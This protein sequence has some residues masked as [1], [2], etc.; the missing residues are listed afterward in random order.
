MNR[1]IHFEIPSEKPEKSLQFYSDVFGWKYEQ[2]GE[3]SY[4]LALT[5]DSTDPG[6]NGAVMLRKDRAQPV[7]NTIEVENIDESMLKIE[8]GDGSIVVPKSVIPNIGEL[9][10]F[11]DPEGNIFGI[12]QSFVRG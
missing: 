6:I 8:Q 3:E 5:G 10:Y 1:V 9:A 2:Y 12:M 4:W 7:V 11:K